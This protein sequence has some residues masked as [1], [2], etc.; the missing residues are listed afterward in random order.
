MVD[1]KAKYTNTENN[2]GIAVYHNVFGVIINNIDDYEEE[3]YRQ[4]KCATYKEIQAWV[5]QKYGLHVNNSNIAETKGKCG[6]EKN[7]YKGREASGKYAPPK[8]RTDKEAAIREA[9]IAFGLIG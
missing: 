9:F 5:K 8:L 4:T 7:A 3:T 2:I 6:L 1:S